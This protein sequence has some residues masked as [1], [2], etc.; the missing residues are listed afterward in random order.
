MATRQLSLYATF[1]YTDEFWRLSPEERANFR[2][3]LAS[4]AESVGQATN[5]YSVYPSRSD[6]DFLVWS[7]WEAEELDAGAKAFKAYNKVSE[8]WRLYV[9]PVHTFWGYTSPSMYSRGKSEQDMDPFDD[10]RSTYLSVYPFSKTKDWYLK[11]MD[12]RQGMMNQHIKLGK[13]FPE[14]KQLLLYC[15]GLQDHE[16]VVSY[17]T[18]DLTK[19][20]DLV[21]DLRGTEARLFT[22]LDTPLLTGYHLSR[23][24]FVKG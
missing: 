7:A 1:S 6:S 20:S 24:E 2:E 11:S 14:I 5:F 15:F 12:S 4:D 8:G 19:F 10:A 13:Q 22:L 17:E 9:K 21:R 3:K 23:E 16:F 18:E